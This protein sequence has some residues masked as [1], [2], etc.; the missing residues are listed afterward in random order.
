M[1]LSGYLRA[2]R[3]RWWLVVLTALLGTGAATVV[4]ARTTP[5]YATSVTFFVSTP[6]RVITDAYQGS[7]LSQQR[8]KSYADLIT[9]DR[10]AKMIN[11]RYR[12]GLSVSEI[13]SRISA[14]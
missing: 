14:Q 5:K 11:D 1:E 10:L 13:Q 9:G 7:M 3:K 2:V 12:L 6:N 4:I 8:V